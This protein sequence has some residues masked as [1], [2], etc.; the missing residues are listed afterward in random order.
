M[1]EVDLKATTNK[2]KVLSC[3]VI[4]DP[5]EIPVPTKKEV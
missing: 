1:N 2:N 5:G 3:K 4:D